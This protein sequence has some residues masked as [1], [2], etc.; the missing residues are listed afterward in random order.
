MAYNVIGRHTVSGGGNR[1]TRTA[2]WRFPPSIYVP[3]FGELNLNFIPLCHWPRFVICGG[4]GSSVLWCVN[5]VFLYFLCIERQRQQRTT[6]ASSVRP[7]PGPSQR[8]RRQRTAPTA[9]SS[10]AASSGSPQ[11]VSSRAVTPPQATTPPFQ[12]PSSSPGSASFSPATSIPAGAVARARGWVVSSSADEQQASL[13]QPDTVRELLAKQD[14]LE[15]TAA[16]M[17]QQVQQH[18]R[19]LR[20]LL[21][22]GRF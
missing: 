1:D 7:Q 13:F 5:I 3:R 22:R 19:T 15:R 12:H 8:R 21:R 18:G 16:L 14:R 9:A 6:A 4:V 20:H 17:L 10:T 11:P 2:V